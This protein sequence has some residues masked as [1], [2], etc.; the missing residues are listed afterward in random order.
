[1]CYTSVP[2]DAFF[3]TARQVA[4]LFAL[5]GTGALCRR[6]RLIDDKSV[7]GLVNIL[8]LVVTPCVIVECFARP[9]A[10]SMFAGLGEAFAVAMTVHLVS[11]AVACFA[12]RHSLEDSR[13]VLRLSTVLS[14]SG[15]MGIPLEQAI[16]GDKGVFYG[17]AFIVAYNL[18]F[19]SW[20][21][22]TMGG[23]ANRRMMFVNPG[24]VGVA[25][26]LLVFI[27][28]WKPPAIVMEPVSMI[29]AL[30]TP[31]AM[32]VI[33]YHLADARL[34]KVLRTPAAH[35]AGALRLF[36]IPLALTAALWPFRNALDRTM[37][38]AS[39]IPA[40]APTGAMVAMFAAKFRRDVDMAVGMV[41]GTTL[42]SML[43]L[44]IVVAIA[45]AVL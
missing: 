3:T 6:L 44:P 23:C 1:M 8:V 5:M 21:L 7:M 26:G 11:I 20:G 35:I 9:F 33:G 29:A 18:V 13:C 27:S 43:T 36:A 19:W 17:V 32:M 25:L 4:V 24:T 12:V 28:P 31:V 14:N 15:F 10:P 41:S 2:V 34:G 39:V 16:L 22:K 40:A 37:M 30:N 38:L 45:E 42:L